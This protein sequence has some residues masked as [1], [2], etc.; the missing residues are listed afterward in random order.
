MI[1]TWSCWQSPFS[2]G[3]VEGNHPPKSNW[4]DECC[5]KGEKNLSLK[6]VRRGW[7]VEI[8]TAPLF[9]NLLFFWMWFFFNLKSRCSSVV[10]SFPSRVPGALYVQWR[11]PCGQICQRPNLLGD[12]SPTQNRATKKKKHRDASK[13]KATDQQIYKQ[14]NKQTNK[15]ASK[16]TNKQTNKLTN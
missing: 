1:N 2:W 7:M 16:Q 3:G 10:D 5:I 13:H 14:T 6:K 4:I 12:L 8:G 9:L 15:Q 11:R